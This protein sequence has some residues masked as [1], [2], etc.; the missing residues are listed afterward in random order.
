MRGDAVIDIGAQRV[1]RHAASRT[2]GAG[3]L[4][5]AKSGRRAMDADASAPS[6]SKS[7]PRASGAAEGDAALKLLGIDSATS[8]GVELWLANFDD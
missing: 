2:F 5:A 7:A 1:E 3:D 8:C 4:G 6:R